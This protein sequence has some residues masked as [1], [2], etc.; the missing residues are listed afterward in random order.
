ML[1]AEASGCT[2]FVI[3]G[4][5][6]YVIYSLRSGRC[7]SFTPNSRLP[8]AQIWRELASSMKKCLEIGLT[9]SFVWRPRRYNAEADEICNACLDKR[10]VNVAIVSQIATPPNASVVEECMLLLSSVRLPSIRLLP[11]EIS[12]QWREFLFS[13]CADES[14][15][16]VIRRKMFFLAP[17]LLSLHTH[18]IGNRNEFKK[19]RSHVGMLGQKEY[20]FES[21]QLLKEKMKSKIEKKQ[22]TETYV[23][24]GTPIE[25]EQKRISTLAARGLFNKVVQTNDV[26]VAKTT[27]EVIEKAKAMFPQSVL[28]APLPPNTIFHE[29]EMSSLAAAILS[30]KRGKAPGLSGWTRELVA[31]LLSFEVL[32]P[33]FKFLVIFFNDVINCNIEHSEDQLL[34]TGALTLLTY[35]ENLEKIRPIVVK[36][37]ILKIA[38][39]CLLRSKPVVLTPI[40]GSVFGKKG[41]SAI[42]VAV[43]QNQLFDGVHVLCCDAKNAFNNCSRHAAFRTLLSPALTHLRDMFPLFNLIYA[44][45]NYALVGEDKIDI[46]TGTSQGDVSG[47]LFLELCKMQCE[48]IFGTKNIKSTSV[49]DDFHFYFTPSKPEELQN[50]HDVIM[51]MKNELGLDLCGPKMKLLCPF[52]TPPIPDL[53][54]EH[55]CTPASILGSV[56]FPPHCTTLTEDELFLKTVCCLKKSLGKVDASVAFITNCPASVQIKFA[57]LRSLQFSSLYPMASMMTCPTTTRILEAIETKYLDL[58]YHLFSFPMGYRDLDHQVRIQSPIEDGG[59]GLLPLTFLRPHLFENNEFEANNL[60]RTLGFNEIPNMRKNN[61]LKVIWKTFYP[62]K[63][64][65]SFSSHSS[66]LTVWPSKPLLT[67]DDPTFVF[68]VQHRLGIMTPFPFK[69]HRAE[70]DVAN[71]EPHAFA[72]H[73]ENCTCCGSKMW[74]MRHEKINYVLARTFKYHNL[75]CEVNPRDLNL[76]GNLRGGPD[77][78]LFVGS[79]IYAGDVR[80]ASGRRQAAFRFNEKMKK[81]KEF[82]EVTTFESFPFVLS[83]K[84]HVCRGTQIILQKIQEE[85]TSKK[86]ASDIICHAQVE[87]LKGMFAGYMRVKAVGATK[88]VLDIENDDDSRVTKR[89]R[90]QV[91]L[92]QSRNS[93]VSLNAMSV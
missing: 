48:S 56:V 55:I 41:G 33:F 38:L 84:G 83:S 82:A 88:G 47:P 81:Y 14:Q 28:P 45:E 71:L 1:V 17:H 65:E 40:P 19:L 16:I 11:P 91:S 6:A 42:A 70:T 13:I 61:D 72:T 23:P 68:G 64:T 32:H 34:R 21:L 30:L 58:F 59:L 37:V 44:K 43:V 7:L 29:L 54:V 67:I 75:A 5:S 93:S 8:N 25:Q 36:D 3:V 20:L 46:T 53:L 2:N 35:K 87:C 86:L 69:C 18:K 74:Y 52:P 77:F 24:K 80:V 4:D 62:I 15:P 51:Y 9:L 10:D 63:T 73:F 85:T 49:S 31:P 39:L 79:K 76:P 57:A 26:M 92:S 50:I 27:P 90:E 12:T 66:F 22:A 89:H 60:R 78:L